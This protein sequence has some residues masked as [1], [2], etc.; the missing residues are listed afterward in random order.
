MSKGEDPNFEKIDQGQADMYELAK[1]YFEEGKYDK[2][3]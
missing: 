2:S 3:V 1:I